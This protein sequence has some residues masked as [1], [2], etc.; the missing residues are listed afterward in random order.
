MDERPVLAILVGG[1][2]RRMGGRPKG[3][4]EA[5]GGGETLI[6]RAVRVGREAGLEPMLVGDAAAYEGRVPDVPRI[7]DDPSGIGPLGG[8]SAVLSRAKGRDVILIGCDMP[9]IDVAVLRRL[10]DHP[11]R[12]P[13]LAARRDD[14]FE[15]LLSR[16]RES[17]ETAIVTALAA[18]VRSFQELL[19]L[20]DVDELEVDEGIARALEDWDAPE[21]V[22]E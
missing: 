18:G 3:L 16:Y 1:Q 12:A 14:R 8:L 13:V 7:A 15:P 2:A 22:R 21:D 17:A 20:L 4:I 19:A 10:I 5:P 11:G 9:S 6:E